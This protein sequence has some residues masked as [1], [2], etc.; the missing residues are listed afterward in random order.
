METHVFAQQ[1]NFI[2]LDSRSLIHLKCRQKHFLNM[3]GTLG[4]LINKIRSQSSFYGLWSSLVRGFCILNPAC[5]I[6]DQTVKVVTCSPEARQQ[7]GSIQI[8]LA[9]RVEE[10][11]QKM[12]PNP[13][14]LHKTTKWLRKHAFAACQSSLAVPWSAL[15]L[16]L[17]SLAKSI[18]IQFH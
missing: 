4:F 1:S 17:E 7:L 12:K 9:E 6:I 5:S 18:C 15:K 16:G 8:G 2:L 13:T 14:Q 3:S 10:R 11:G